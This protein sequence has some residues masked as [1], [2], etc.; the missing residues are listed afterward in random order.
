[1][2]PKLSTSALFSIEDIWSLEQ[3]LFIEKDSYDVMKMAGKGVF[4][5]ILADYPKPLVNQRVH[6]VLGSGNN[7]GDGLIVAG[8]LKSQGFSVTAYQVFTQPF[9]GDAEKAFMFAQ[10]QKVP[11]VPFELFDCSEKDII[12]DAI[13]GIGLTRPAEGKAQKAIQHINDCRHRYSQLK[14]YA[15]DV[16]SGLFADTGQALGDC[17]VADITITFIADKIGLHT[18]D[19]KFCSG[20]VSVVSLGAE[21]HIGQYQPTI[22]RYHYQDNK[23]ITLRTNQHKGNFGHV[24]VIGGGRNLFGAAALTS[25]SALKVGVGKVSLLTH[26]DYQNQYHIKETPL[27]E[28]MR[29]STLPSVE[30]LAIFS[31]VVLGTGLGRDEWG[32]NYFEQTLQ[33]LS[34][35]QVHSPRVLPLLIDADGLWHLAATKIN[36]GIPPISVITPHESEAARL[37]NTG[38]A[39]VRSDKVTAVRQLAQRYQCIAVLKGAGTLISNGET[40][41]INTSGNVNLATA[42]SGDVLSGIIGG[43]LAKL[44]RRI[45]TPET[46]L[47][48]VLYGVYQHGLAAD[49]YAK[50]HDSKSLRASELW[51]YL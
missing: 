7:A 30:E 8:L 40:V 41:W 46:L 4:D 26:E 18:G 16:P 9:V 2:K 22:F 14:V 19:G 3:S 48:A 15:V 32:K 44:N 49:S 43:H 51:N 34:E 36:D 21:A 13:F 47:S 1:M 39:E 31:A 33:R 6:I 37:L 50:N 20:T 12:V 11:I 38:V 29:C 5:V 27:Y 23:N 28:V 17:V 35:S 10:Q 24:L 25:I 42:G 45:D